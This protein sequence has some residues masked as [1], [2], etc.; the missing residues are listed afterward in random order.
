MPYR[1]PFTCFIRRK[2]NK[3]KHN[4]LCL[5]SSL[6]EGAYSRRGY[7]LQRAIHLFHS[8]HIRSLIF[9][10]TCC[11]LFLRW[12][13]C[14]TRL[15][16]AAAAWFCFCIKQNLISNEL[17]VSDRSQQP[18]SHLISAVKAVAIES[19]VVTLGSLY[20]QWERHLNSAAHPLHKE[21]FKEV[22]WMA[23]W[24]YSLIDEEHR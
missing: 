23:L 19:Q 20:S 22:K 4:C 18:I 5:D 12:W 11:F 17:L 9:S 13:L 2:K 21:R 8:T 14:E 15:E 16:M 3:T 24:F 1:M 7:C 10:Q 6:I